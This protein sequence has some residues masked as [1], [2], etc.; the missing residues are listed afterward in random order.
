LP[1]HDIK[2]HPPERPSGTATAATD[3]YGRANHVTS[4]SPPGS[5]NVPNDG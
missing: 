2:E 3:R 4:L 1:L 5:S